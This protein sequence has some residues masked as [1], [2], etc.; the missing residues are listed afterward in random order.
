MILTM[1]LNQWIHNYL[2]VKPDGGCKKIP[3]T[4]SSFEAFVEKV[5]N[6]ARSGT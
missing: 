2:R 6:Y 3:G 1:M 4:L 5:V